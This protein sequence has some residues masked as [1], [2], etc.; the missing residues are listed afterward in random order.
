MAHGIFKV[1]LT[2]KRAELPGH[3]ARKGARKTI[4]ETFG[5]F[6]MLGKSTSSNLRLSS[7]ELYAVPLQA[8]SYPPLHGAV[9]CQLALRQRLVQQHRDARGHRALSP[10]TRRT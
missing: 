6:E 4:L 10:G 8:L 5:K 1:L 9:A 7:P 2:E 3:K